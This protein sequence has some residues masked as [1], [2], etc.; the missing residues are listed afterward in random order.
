MHKKIIAAALAASVVTPFAMAD[1]T[2]YG[3]MSA[4]I[5]SVQGTGGSVTYPSRVRVTDNNSRIGFKGFED[6]GNG[7]QSIWQVENSLKYFEQGGTNDAGQTATFATRNTFV[8]LASAQLGT[9]QLGYL[10]SAYKRLTNGGVNVMGDTAADIDGTTTNVA[11]I[12]SRGEARLKNSVN[13]TTPVWKG[14]QG[15]I[16]YGVDEGQISSTNTQPSNR[17][18]LSLAA[19]YNWNS[20]QIGAGWDHTEHSGGYL[21]YFNGI[22]ATSYSA[23]AGSNGLSYDAS[24]NVDFSKLVASYKFTTGTFIA[25]GVERGTYGVAGSSNMAQT[26]WTVAATQ[27]IGNATVKMSYSRLGGLSNTADPDAYKASEWVLGGTYSLSKTTQL[28]AYYARIDNNALSNVDFANT[29]LYSNS[30]GSSSATLATGNR[31]STI[32]MGMKMTF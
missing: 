11:A 29:P 3:V 14:L 19:Q 28:L 17:N 16:S 21:G 30:V 1:V 24:G 23:S 6:L 18:H 2:L 15:G 27:D 7:L 20:L 13:Y 31:L 26:G 10:D 8:G 4:S 12:F 5:E 25:A 22:N 9:M 32:G